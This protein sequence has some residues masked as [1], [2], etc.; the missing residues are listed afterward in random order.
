MNSAQLVSRLT[1][2][3]RSNFYYAFLFLP[4]PQRAALYAVYAFCRIV[5][6]VADLGGDPARQR[7]DLREWRAEVARCFDPAGPRVWPVKGEDGPEGDGIANPCDQM[8]GEDARKRDG[9]KNIPVCRS[10]GVPAFGKIADTGKMP[11]PRFNLPIFS[12]PAQKSPTAA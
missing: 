6:D 7:A 11:V 9:A 2:Q 8:A 10:H 3:S 5:D 4:R 12:I 1:R